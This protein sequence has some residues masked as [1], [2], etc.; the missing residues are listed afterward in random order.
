MRIKQNQN[1]FK[2]STNYI[3]PKQVLSC[4]TNIENTS[5]NIS[6]MRTPVRNESN[7]IQV[8]SSNTKDGGNV[9][10]EIETSPPVLIPRTISQINE[11]NSL[12]ERL[13]VKPK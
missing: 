13:I 1:S 8:K 11:H 12:T 5:N 7:V 9:K 3:E 4:N 2:N 10:N 6:E